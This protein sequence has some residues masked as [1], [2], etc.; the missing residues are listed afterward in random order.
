MALARTSG[1]YMAEDIIAGY[2]LFHVLTSN[3]L[4][5][6]IVSRREF[7]YGFEDVMSM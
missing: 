5:K 2:L 1:G 3:L 7:V 6:N 4:R